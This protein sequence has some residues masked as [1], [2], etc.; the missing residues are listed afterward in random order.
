MYSTAINLRAL[1][2]LGLGEKEKAE[3]LLTQILEKQGDYQG[4]L[5]QK[6]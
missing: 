5:A 4:A 2:H 3:G 6:R 1:G